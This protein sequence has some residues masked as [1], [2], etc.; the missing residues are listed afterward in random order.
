MN[1]SLPFRRII[2]GATLMLTVAGVAVGA[3]GAQQPEEESLVTSGQ[4][5]IVTDKDTYAVG[6]PVTITYTLPSP[7]RYRI[8]DRQGGRV[9]TLRSGFSAQATGRIQGTV[10]PPAG[11]ECLH[12]EYTDSKNRT[13]TAETCFEVTDKVDTGQPKGETPAPGIYTVLSTGSGLMLDSNPQKQVYSLTA[14]GG[15]FQKWVLEAG[16]DGYFFLRNLATSYYL[17]SNPSG[18]VYTLEKNFGQYQQWKVEPV[19]GE[20]ASVI[21]PRFVLRNR[22][23]GLPLHDEEP[24]LVGQA[25]I[26][27]A[28]V[29]DIPV[30]SNVKFHWQLTAVQP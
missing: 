8:T 3:V 16:P 6:E 14:N 12:L 15:A 25:D 4:T 17:D 7:G 5:S 21:E 18:D 22:A 13:S 11:K 29:P 30:E 26:I 2:L 1:V 20:Y 23:T 19:T 27:R 28:Q 10:T 24:E 9:S